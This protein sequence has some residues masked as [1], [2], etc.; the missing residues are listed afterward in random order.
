MVCLAQAAGSSVG[1][2][3]WKYRGLVLHQVRL[4]KGTRN[5]TGALTS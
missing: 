1:I 5:S 3:A 4:Q 2:E